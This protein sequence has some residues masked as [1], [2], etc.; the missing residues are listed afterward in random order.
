VIDL[1]AHVL[2]GL[3]DG[4]ETMLEAVEIL[5]SMAADGV[6][7]VCATP[8]VRDDYPT[9]ADE[10]EDGVGRLR[11][12]AAEAGVDIDVRRGGEIALDRLA[13]LDPDE[14]AR[15]G[16][17]GNPRLLLIEFPYH[18]WPLSLERDCAALLRDDVVPVLAH[19]ERNLEVQEAPGRLEQAVRLGAVVQLTAASVDGR[20][21]EEARGCART[22]LAGGLAHTVA[23]DAHTAWVREA[24]LTRAEGSV[25]DAGMWRWLV[26]DAPAALLAGE[27]LPARPV[28][29]RRERRWG[30][31]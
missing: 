14:R 18:G 23:S 20:L 10:M 29:A 5:R 17:G 19:P 16:L 15:F 11:A 24:G 13:G 7:V 30:R 21:G 27:P 26:E 1:H 31:S 9:T 12:A 28:A 8:H 22:L 25:G 6:R 3:D 4:P 2:P